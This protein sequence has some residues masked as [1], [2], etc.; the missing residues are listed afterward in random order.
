MIDYSVHFGEGASDPHAVRE[1][2]ALLPAFRGA[3]E[4]AAAWLSELLP[5]PLTA[6]T[7]DG[8]AAADGHGLA[9]L[10]AQQYALFEQLARCGL[11][12]HAVIGS[13]PTD[14]LA[15]AAAGAIDW[16][17]GL[18]LA[19]LHAQLMAS[20]TP[21]ATII[22]SLRQVRLEAGLLH[23]RPTHCTLLLASCDEPIASGAHVPP[24]HMRAQ[25]LREPR[26][27]P[28]PAATELACACVIELGGAPTPAAHGGG[29]LH[30]GRF[31]DV[32]RALGT[33]FEL[34]L[35]IDFSTLSSASA[36]SPLSLP[37]YP[38]QHPEPASEPV[39][40][41]APVEPAHARSSHPLLRHM[42][43]SAA[44]EPSELEPRKRKHTG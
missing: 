28:H 20:L 33:L 37:S 18:R 23:Y 36:R 5:L 40:S 42:T 15:A 2:C 19:L 38:F 25:L 4:R 17:S 24:D 27:A 14:C 22:R 32:L 16:R 12:P 21:G 34:G 43:R 3:F 31:A 8:A 26:S 7:L 39:V 9:L 29:H 41:H 6:A 35:D 11:R 30:V 1:L 10:F 44:S 13:D